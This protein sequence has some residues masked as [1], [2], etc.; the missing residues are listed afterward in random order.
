MIKVIPDIGPPYYF[1]DNDGDG[2]IDTDV[3]TSDLDRGSRVNMWKILE[4]D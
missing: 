4:W 3:R 2:D 1:I